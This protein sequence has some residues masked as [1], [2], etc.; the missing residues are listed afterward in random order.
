MF[1]AGENS[2]PLSSRFICL[3]ISAFFVLELLLILHHPLWQDEWQ[4]W[5]IARGS[6]SLN[7][8]LHNMRYEGHP[9]LWYLALYL[10]SRWTSNPLAMQLFH[11]VLAAGTAWIF[12]RYAPFTRLHKILFI[13]GYFPFFE[14]AV[15]SRNYAGGILLVFT[16]CA[17][18]PRTF[19]KRNLVL[20]GLL[21]L[22]CQ[23]SVYGVLLALALGAARI[24]GE[25]W[26]NRHNPLSLK[27]DLVIFSVILGAGIFLAVLQLLPDSGFATDWRFNFNWP[28][29][30]QAFNTIWESYIPLPG[31]NY[32]FWNT[33]LIQ[34]PYLKLLLSILLLGFPLLLFRRQPAILALFFLG[35][36]AILSFTYTKYLGSLRHHGHLFILLIVSLWLS[37]YSPDWPGKP[38]RLEKAS[39]CCQQRHGFI[40]LILAAQLTAGLLAASLSL[41]YP[42]SAGQETARYIKTHSLANM[43]IAADD[44]DA[45]SVISGYLNRPL[46]YLCANRR[47]TFVIWDQHRQDLEVSEAL[48]RGREL[49]RRRHREVLLVLNQEI[50]TPGPDIISLRRCTTSI[51]PTEVYYLYKLTY[52]GE[53]QAP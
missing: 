43:L 39:G 40:S 51:V 41:A 36:L 2:V 33:N 29:M 42:F 8:L 50:D 4:A 31:L 15:I 32:H 12:L 22:L 16:Y 38:A 3:L 25:F 28:V 14:Y 35:T 13:F 46:Y 7:E 53:A 34:L 1:P 37:H 18:F 9:G 49:A 27:R 24:V 52:P 26:H 6:G 11:L 45:A 5:L 17:I 10:L 19:P 30:M 47:G 44:D 20:A 48:R 23:T 21:F